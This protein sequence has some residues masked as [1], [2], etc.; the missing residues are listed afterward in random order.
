VSDL[1][2]V[3]VGAL[4]GLGVLVAASGWTEPPARRQNRRSFDYRWVLVLV[5]GLFVGTLVFAASGW[6][7]A[8]VAA[9]A[10]TIALAQRRGSRRSDRERVEALASWAEQLRDTLGAGHGV[11]ETIEATA[12]I[13]PEPIRVQVTQL[14]WR[15]RREAPRSALQSF[16]DSLDDPTADLI[17]AILA[18]AIERSGRA[19]SELL[20][21]LADTARD[22]VEMSLRVDSERASTRAEARWVAGSSAFMMIALVV[23]GQ[24]WLKPYSTAT[25]QFVLACVFGLYGAGA[26]G[27]A[28]L[29]RYR[30]VERFL[31]TERA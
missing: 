25:G 8:G 24:H 13:A 30:D 17:V 21:E 2:R 9:C 16:A 28:R 14:A 29:S 18:L 5:I 22:R 4:V 3:L 10:A 27:L 12:R 19:A 26:A 23:F 11:A 7:I 15:L 31:R 6:P 1:L 20:S